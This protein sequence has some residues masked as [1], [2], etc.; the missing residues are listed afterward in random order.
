ML[1]TNKHR[2]YFIA[3]RIY[4]CCLLE[5]RTH[6]ICYLGGYS[7]LQRLLRVKWA[8][9]QQTG[10]AIAVAATSFTVGPR[11]FWM[12]PC[13]DWRATDYLLHC[14]QITWNANNAHQTAILIIK[15]S[16]GGN[17]WKSISSSVL[18]WKL[19]GPTLTQRYAS[20]DV[21]YHIDITGI[22][23]Q[24]EAILTKCFWCWITIQFL[25]RSIPAS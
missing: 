20:E 4:I 16:V 23:Q 24:H 21:I 17:S 1:G 14:A 9:A 8:S 18:N 7:R 12:G 15:R 5:I 6:Q 19:S 10:F 3:V 13:T 22:N 11:R 2:Q 25:C